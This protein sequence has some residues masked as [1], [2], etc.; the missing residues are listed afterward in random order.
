MSNIVSGTLSFSG[1]CY[2]NIVSNTYDT[3]AGGYNNIV[4]GT[5]SNI[6]GGVINVV[7][8]TGIYATIGGGV[9]NSVSTNSGTISG[10]SNNTVN[11]ANATV[12]GGASNLAQ[13][14]YSFAAGKQAQALD[15]GT[16]VWAD[17]SGTPFTST[18]NNQFL[19]RASGGVGIGTTSPAAN[20][21]T[22]GGGGL[23]VSTSGTTFAEIQAGTASL[24][25]GSGGVTNIY[26][27]TFPTAFSNPP[28][29]IVTTR[30]DYPT[31][32]VPDT[33]AVTVRKVFTNTFVVNVFRVDSNA[34]IGQNLKL[35]WF[36]WQ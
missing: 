6:G 14:S 25:T 19:V 35:D 5:E 33:F 21:L 23:R 10:G 3:I 7:A 8:S 17:S 18:A 27:V 1:A 26:T 2:K 24:G 16:F 4:N 30:N 20:T 11:G 12:P 34:G 22:V 29:V 36:A 28:K 32:D 13:G 15:P 9:G 31:W